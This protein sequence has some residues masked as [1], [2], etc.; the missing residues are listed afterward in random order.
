MT[1][2]EA[3]A[4][5]VAGAEAHIPA[6]SFHKALLAIWDLV[7]AGNKYIDEAQ[8][9]ALA[10]AAKDDPGAAARLGEVLYHIA[11]GLRVSAVLIAPFMPRKMAEL[12]ESLGMA[13][14]L[15]KTPF[16]SVRRWGGFERATLRKAAPLFPKVENGEEEA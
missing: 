4:A 15:E 5:A 9:W 7:R 6:L 3:A 14:S 16:E 13:E 10:K 11:E 8:P 2:R 12:W 1:L